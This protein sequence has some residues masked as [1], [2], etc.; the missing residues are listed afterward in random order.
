MQR[1]FPEEIEGK[2][3]GNIVQCRDVGISILGNPQDGIICF[4]EG[5][6]VN[7]GYKAEGVSPG[8]KG[9]VGY[10]RVL[11]ALGRG[12]NW[13]KVRL[14]SRSEG[15]CQQRTWR[16]GPFRARKEGLRSNRF[17][18]E[19]K[20]GWKQ[21]RGPGEPRILGKEEEGSDSFQTEPDRTRPNHTGTNRT[22]PEEEGND[23]LRT[24]PDWAGLNRTE[25]DR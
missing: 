18:R 3:M 21:G 19:R 13:K 6:R 8:K 12:R 15:G 9:A 22:G 16:V 23:S 4:V 10:Y 14:T 25:P 1:D 11:P 5:D 17:R 24:E 20:W 7:P 2:E